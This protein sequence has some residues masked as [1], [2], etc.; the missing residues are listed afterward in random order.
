MAS[1]LTPYWASSACTFP[2]SSSRWRETITRSWPCPASCRANSAPIPEV[3]PVIITVC[4]VRRARTG[5]SWRGAGVGDWGRSF[6]GT[7]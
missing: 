1:T 5:A 4:P 2:A 3:A 7:R 6:W